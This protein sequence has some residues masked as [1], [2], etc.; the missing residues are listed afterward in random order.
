MPG[1]DQSLTLKQI[2]DE[3]IKN[4][5]EIKYLIEAS[6]TRILLKIEDLKIAVHKLEKKNSELKTTVEK[7]KREIMRNNLMIF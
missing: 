2:H 1:K 7:L 5:K 4:R 3:I 6:K